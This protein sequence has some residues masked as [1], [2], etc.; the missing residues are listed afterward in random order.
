MNDD[1]DSSSDDGFSD[2][3][4]RIEEAQEVR[5]L[6]NGDVEADMAYQK[7]YLDGYQAASS[8]SGGGMDT[9]FFG[10]TG[11]RA[12]AFISKL[13]G[14]S[15]VESGGSK[16]PPVYVEDPKSV[17]VALED[18]HSGASMVMESSPVE[19]K[20]T[21]GNSAVFGTVGRQARKRSQN[22][23]QKALQN[24]AYVFQTQP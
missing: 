6:I 5:D 20:D 19:V 16:L 4:S 2:A 10:N 13:G 18:E 21:F 8:A 17:D 11:K 9:S 23:A 14:K 1:L 3:A 15:S 22:A 12:E 24:G 7:G